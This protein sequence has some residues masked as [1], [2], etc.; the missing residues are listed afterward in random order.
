M[1]ARRLARCLERAAAA[2]DNGN[3]AEAAQALAEARALDSE[4]PDVLAL[5]RR[6][7]AP[8]PSSRRTRSVVIGVA[9]AALVIAAAAFGAW[10]MTRTPGAERPAAVALTAPASESGK[11]ARQTT[12]RPSLR[13]QRDTVIV[14]EQMPTMIGTTG[15]LVAG[16]TSSSDAPAGDEPVAASAP[17]ST[18]P[19][20]APTDLV[21]AA[22]LLMTAAPE[23]LPAMDLPAPPPVAD[24][25]IRASV[26]APSTPEPEPARASAPSAAR[27]EP[28]PN[29][30]RVDPREQV[31]QVLT[32]YEAAYSRLDAQAARAVWPSVDEKA[33]ARAFDGLASQDVSL[34]RCDVEILGQYARA[35]CTG[36]A[37][38]I[39]K[40]GGGVKTQ[41]RRWEFQLAQ[42]D[43]GWEIVKAGVR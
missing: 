7:A 31:R 13:I 16:G 1:R 8:T 41:A 17:A 25:P 14:P 11:A 18:E 26:P 6:L 32:R 23:R 40:I 3:R 12:S 20:S 21:P 4:A 43:S 15:E 34:G 27:T 42:A 29:V 22:P 33:L 19:D 5:E 10:K 36:T 38:W 30:V 2:L 35:H 37:K 39:P 24:A 28:P 9:S